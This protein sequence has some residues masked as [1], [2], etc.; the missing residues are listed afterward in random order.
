[1]KQDASSAGS[2]WPR[3]AFGPAV[4]MTQ[5]AGR[6][7]PSVATASPTGSPSGSVVAR[8]CRHA[9]S[10][11]G[12]AAAWIAPSTPPPP[13]SEELAA[14]TIASASWVVMSPCRQVIRVMAPSCTALWGMR[15]RAA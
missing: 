1:M 14:F 11:R 2:V 9:A 8:S 10:S 15:R 6:S 4:W 5:R 13:S 12:P 7:N 3:C